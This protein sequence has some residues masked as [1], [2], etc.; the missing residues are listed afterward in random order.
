MED[1]VDR[2]R[3]RRRKWTNLK[4]R[5]GVRG[6]AMGCCGGSWSNRV[7]SIHLAEEDE[8]EPENQLILGGNVASNDIRAPS[9]VAGG[10]VAPGTGMN[11]AMAL[12]AERNLRAAKVGSSTEAKT[13][14][15]LIEETD[16][17]DLEIKTSIDDGGGNDW[18][19][20]VCMERKKGAALIP[21]GHTF[22]RVCSRELWVSRGSC[23]VCN[24]PIL[25]ILDIF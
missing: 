11:L 21:C 15:K 19:C 7:L 13:L 24:R 9:A 4:R 16:G 6:I 14:L 8:E 1:S 17:V 18:V 10:V 25:E 23:P 5:L 3:R 20:C 22:C 12:E 2:R